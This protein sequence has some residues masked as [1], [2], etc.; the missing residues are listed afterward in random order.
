MPIGDVDADEIAFA[1]AAA[2]ELAEQ[3]LELRDALGGLERR[4]VLAELILKWAQQL[5]PRGARRRRR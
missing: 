2:G 5:K 1:E 3:A 4:M